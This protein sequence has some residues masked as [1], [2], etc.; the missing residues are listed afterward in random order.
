MFTLN[1]TVAPGGAYLV[2]GMPVSAPAGAFL[3]LGFENNTAGPNVALVA[4]TDAQFSSGA[5]GT[6]LSDS[7]G[8]G[9]KFLTLL[10]P[11]TIEGKVIFVRHVVGT[12]P[13]TFTLTID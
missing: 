4:G 11:H 9:F 5:G 6:H 8:P 10:A 1:G 2:T 12:V 7:G 3:K 13:A